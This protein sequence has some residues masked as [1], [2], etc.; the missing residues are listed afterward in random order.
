MQRAKLL[1]QENAVSSLDA[2]SPD[3]FWVLPL[4]ETELPDFYSIRDLRFG[5]NLCISY[6][7]SAYNVLELLLMP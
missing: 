4:K 5:E 2:T 3:L 7:V 1:A 6:V